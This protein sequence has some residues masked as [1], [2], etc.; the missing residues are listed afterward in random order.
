MRY[1]IP[2]LLCLS[3][4]APHRYMDG[5][6]MRPPAPIVVEPGFTPPGTGLPEYW[7]PPE[8]KPD[9]QPNPRPKRYLPPTR[10]PGMWSAEEPKASIPDDH[11]KIDGIPLVYP[12]DAAKEVQ[13]LVNGCAEFMDS[14]MERADH[15]RTRRDKMSHEERYCLMARLYEQCPQILIPFWE[16]QRAAG[17]R[18][19]PHGQ[20]AME[21]I[22]D[23]AR[24]MRE[25]YCK[26]VLPFPQNTES[27]FAD[28]V[29]EFIRTGR[30]LP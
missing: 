30:Y 1:L 6:P 18:Y 16:K 26:G 24:I 22:R 28:V 17:E 10:E 19:D 27:L 2:L 20:K 29:R 23:F 15:D 11:P 13:R 7:V 4:S 8:H 25:E 21:S 3:C 5:A 9:V 12:P 14:A